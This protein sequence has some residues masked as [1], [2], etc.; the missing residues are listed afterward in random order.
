MTRVG[1]F[2]LI[3]ALC[4]P[5]ASFAEDA[6]EIKKFKSRIRSV[7]GQ[8]VV[9]DDVGALSQIRRDADDNWSK[10]AD[11]RARARVYLED[12]FGTPSAGAVGTPPNSNN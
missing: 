7:N 8:G 9:G 10:R 6:P 3:I 5:L 12:V 1:F 2:T 4:L 11:E